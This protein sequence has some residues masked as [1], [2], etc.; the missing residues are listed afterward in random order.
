MFA[1]LALTTLM[2]QSTAPAAT[3]PWP[4]AGVTR[5]S[6]EIVAPVLVKETKPLFSDKAQRAKVQGVVTMEAVIGRDGKVGEVRVVR[7][8]DRE[9]GLDE[10]AVKAVKQW[11]FK[12]GTKDGVAVPVLVEIEMSFKLR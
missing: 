3:E 12:A 4:P 2:L 6:K 5:M 9:F 10:E 11:E 7:S 8:L 1:A